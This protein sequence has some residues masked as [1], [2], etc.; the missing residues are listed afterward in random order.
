[1][2][3]CCSEA[4]GPAAVEIRSDLTATALATGSETGTCQAL[5]YG[6]ACP[7]WWP[8]LDRLDQLLLK[9]KRAV[10]C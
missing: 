8:G 7:A 6:A 10:V 5:P 1:M 4:L 9:R 3:S 2:E